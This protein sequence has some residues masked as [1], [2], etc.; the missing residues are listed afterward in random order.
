M[1]NKLKK[2]LSL[3]LWKEPQVDEIKESQAQLTITDGRYGALDHIL[4]HDPDGYGWKGLSI[5]EKFRIFHTPQS[6]AERY[7]FS[8]ATLDDFSHALTKAY[9]TTPQEK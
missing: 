6:P 3:G 2:I 5:D 8:G 9:K 4:T 7:G 1:T